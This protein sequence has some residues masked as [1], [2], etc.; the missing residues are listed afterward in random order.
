ML[1]SEIIVSNLGRT[2]RYSS[3]RNSSPIEVGLMLVSE[4]LVSNLGR[5]HARLR[6][7]RL[8]R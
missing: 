3:Q 2:Y 7:T 8:S 5:T 6:E 4:K 1:V